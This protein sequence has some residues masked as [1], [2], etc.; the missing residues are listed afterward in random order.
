VRV[1]CTYIYDIILFAHVHSQIAHS[2]RGAASSVY[3]R[4]AF[5][6]SAPQI[7]RRLFEG[8]VYSRK[9]GITL[10]TTLRT[11]FA[12]SVNYPQDVI[13]TLLWGCILIKWNSPLFHDS[14]HVL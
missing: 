9:Y 8:G 10:V 14:S 1:R 12:F 11:I 3:S 4:A 2:G 13:N 5:I 7:V 6:R